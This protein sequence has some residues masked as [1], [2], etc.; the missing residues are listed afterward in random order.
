MDDELLA[1]CRA[2]WQEGDWDCLSQLTADTLQTHPDRAKVALLAAAGH[3]HRCNKD[4]VARLVRLARDSGCRKKLIAQVLVAGLCNTLGRAYMAS[5]QL[6]RAETHFQESVRVVAEDDDVGALGEGRAVCETARLGLLPQAAR[7]MDAQLAA[8]KE[9]ATGRAARLKMI[10]T[11]LDLLHHELSIAQ[12]RQQLGR[13]RSGRDDAR[14]QPSVTEWRRSLND[15]AVS[16][17]GQE[18]WVLERTGYKRG[19]FF[20]EFGA[21][22]GVLL[23]NTWL[24][25]TE[26]GWSGIC[27]EPNPKF[28]SQLQENRECKVSQ[29]CIGRVSGQSLEF[30]LADAFGGNKEFSDRD[31][32]KEKRDAY[33]AAG[34]VITMKSISLDDFLAQHDAPRHIDYISIDTEGS[35]YDILCEFPFDKWNVQLFTIEHNYS[36]QREEIRC[37]LEAHGYRR[38]EARWDDWYEKIE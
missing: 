32:H 13:E 17:L 27:A 1:R 2:Q 12:R 30:I 26:F 22:D 3:L 33:A 14:H 31:Q 38:T 21:T 5:G 28:F 18:L 11:E 15:K 29:E 25:E 36:D 10:E 16:Q 20:V 8:A 35:E 9:G 23:S 34:H 7:Y 4:E 19:G 24:L 37:L 6:Q